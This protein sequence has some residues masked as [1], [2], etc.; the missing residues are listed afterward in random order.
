MLPLFFAAFS[1][2]AVGQNDFTITAT[3]LQPSA[4]EPGLPTSAAI[5]L[6]PVTP[7]AGTPVTLTCTVTTNQVTTF[8][9]TCTPSPNPATPFAQASITVGT[10]GS[11]P[12]AYTFT[13]TGTSGTFTHSVQLGLNIVPEA[14]DYTIAVTTAISPTSVAA[15][16]GA[17]ATITVTPIGNY[18]GHQITLSCLSVTPVVAASPVCSFKPEPVS[19]TSNT[20]PTSVLTVTTFGTATGGI[21]KRKT[22]RMLY[23]LWLAVPGLALMGV[24]SRGKRRRNILGML[25][26][27]ALAAGILFMPACG[28]TS[29]AGSGTR[30]PNGNSTPNGTYMFTLSAVDETGAAP[31]NITTSEATVSLTVTTP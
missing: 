19:V 23:G 22:L 26:L 24:C 29:T 4:V 10:Q 18:S 3:Q 17:Q 20:T 7:G 25:L 9:P 31:S 8:L 2:L 1:C 12:G 13:V 6:Q 5:T 27:I 30:A 14:A 21:A 15:G 16:N 11:P 28:S